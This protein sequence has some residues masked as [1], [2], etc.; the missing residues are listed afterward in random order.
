MKKHRF[1][2]RKP[3]Q[4]PYQPP[5]EWRQPTLPGFTGLYHPWPLMRR[6]GCTEAG[7]STPASSPDPTDQPTPPPPNERTLP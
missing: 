1:P 4:F 6:P 7:P 3:P 2:D 5:P